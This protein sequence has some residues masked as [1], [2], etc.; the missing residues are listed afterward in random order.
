MEDDEL[1][2]RVAHNMVSYMG[3]EIETA[4]NG[5][6]A[7]EKYVEAKAVGKPFDVVILDL[8]IRG[9]M[10]GKETVRKLLEI[11]PS[12]RAIVTSGYSLDPVLSNFRDFGFRDAI[13]KP[14]QIQQ[15]REVLRKVMEEESR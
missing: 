14:C 4:R 3:H 10:G 2:G 8:T 5:N 6:E 15:L 12:V 7:V 9:G 11:D 1:L 13:S